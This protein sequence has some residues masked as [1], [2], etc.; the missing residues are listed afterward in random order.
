M[1]KIIIQVILVLFSSL[2]AEVL[3]R[4]DDPAG[5]DYGNGKILYPENPMYAERVFD[6]QSFEFVLESENYIIKI[7]TSGKI[8]PVDHDEFKFNYNLTDNFILPLIHIYIDNDHVM[9]SGFTET[10]HGVNATIAAESAWEKVI[11][12]ASLPQRYKG[13]LNRYQPEVSY[14]AVVPEKITISRDRRELSVKVPKSFLGEINQDWGFTVLMLCQD[15]SQTVQKS[16]YVKD[17]KSTASQ[18]NFGG[19]E[20]N[21][22]QNYDSN[23]IDILV[24]PGSD[25]K[26]I[27]NSYDQENKKLAELKAVYPYA[28]KLITNKAVG[29]VKQ[30]SSD[31]VVINLGSEN[32]VEVGSQLIINHKIVVIAEDVFAQLTIAS[33]RAGSSHLEI[34]EGMKVTLLNK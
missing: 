29:E 17:I 26:R 8:E 23:I 12:I 32:G 20:G 7:R 34:T 27:L 15:Y 2:C 5:D 10:I 18:H 19:G 6:I 14:N 30:V 24:P 1:K 33:L 25:Q 31:K 11:V 22:L 3:F 13:E 16:I 21:L 9:D 28:S 4:I